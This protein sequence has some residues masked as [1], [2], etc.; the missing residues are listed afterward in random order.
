MIKEVAGQSARIE[1]GETFKQLESALLQRGFLIFPK[2]GD[3]PDGYYRVIRANSILS[4]LLNALTVV[5]PDGD[6]SLAR[7]LVQLKQRPREDFLDEEH[8]P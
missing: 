1:I 5:G 6:S 4:N 7:L 3:S 8:T 2:P